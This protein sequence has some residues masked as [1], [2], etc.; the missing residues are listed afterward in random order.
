MRN[1][2][3][4]VVVLAVATAL[5]AQNAGKPKGVFSMLKVGQ[6]VGLKDEGAAYSIGFLEPEVLQSHT[7]IE[8]GEDYVVL[9]DIA[10]VKETTVPVF[11]VKSIE[12]VRLKLE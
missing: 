11:S 12:K 5:G 9:E 10:G 2:I 6:A 3:W 1:W 8:I 7:V 4:L